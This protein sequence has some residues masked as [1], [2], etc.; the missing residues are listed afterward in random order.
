MERTRCFIVK[1]KKLLKQDIQISDI[2]KNTCVKHIY[3]VLY[4]FKDIYVCL[5]VFMTR[6]RSS[7]LFTLLVIVDKA[8]GR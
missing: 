4:I 6:K 3:K 7:E 2:G 8:G 1:V 5:C